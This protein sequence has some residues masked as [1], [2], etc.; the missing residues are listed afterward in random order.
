MDK[1][2]FI[3][4]Y[5]PLSLCVLMGILLLLMQVFIKNSQRHFLNYVALLGLSLVGLT[6]ILSVKMLGEI[7]T[8]AIRLPVDLKQQILS[9]YSFLDN[10]ALFFYLLL[11]VGSFL[12][13]LSASSYLEREN[14]VRGEF[15]ALIFFA[16]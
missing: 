1:L 5:A 9:H 7:S 16:L 6:T 13:V 14:L 4:P 10:F 3:L 2:Y 12:T 15:F 8:G 11:I